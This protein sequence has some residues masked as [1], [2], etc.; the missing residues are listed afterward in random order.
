MVS[1]DGARVLRVPERWFEL[2]S[3]I[4]GLLMVASLCWL[5]GQIVAMRDDL[6]ALKVQVPLQVQGLDRRVSSV[7]AREGD[8]EHTLLTDSRERGR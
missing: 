6:N 7:E 8:L 4:I 2:G 5:G 1:L 3:T